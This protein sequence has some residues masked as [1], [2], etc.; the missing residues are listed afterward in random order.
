MQMQ[1]EI[2]SLKANEYLS[3]TVKETIGITAEKIKKQQKELA[4]SVAKI[5]ST[6]PTSDGISNL[7]DKLKKFDKASTSLVII[8]FIN[9]AVI[10]IFIAI[11]AVNCYFGYK[12]NQKLNA[13]ENAVYT[14][15]GYSAINQSRASKAVHD[16]MQMQQQQKQK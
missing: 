4:D 15:D 7:S 1:S 11:L 10:V 8:N 13:L 9:A 3:K 14:Q 6:L 5:N 2:K 12:T 16:A